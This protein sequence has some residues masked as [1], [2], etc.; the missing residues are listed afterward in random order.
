MHAAAVA[1]VAIVSLLALLALLALLSL[2][3]CRR[4]AS[5]TTISAD[6]P[7]ASASSRADAAPP[8]P[9]KPIDACVPAF[10]RDAPFDGAWL[11]AG[12][13][14]FCAKVAE[15]VP[16]AN[17]RACF[18]VELATGTYHARPNDLAAPPRPPST[19][20]AAYEAASLGGAFTFDLKGGQRTPHGATA[21][22]RDAKTSKKRTAA[23][24]Y[25][26]HLFFDGWVGDAV[27]LSTSVDE[28]P[29]CVRALYQPLKTWP[30]VLYAPGTIQ[31]GSCYGADD[32]V[33]DTPTRKKAIIDG[34]DGTLLLVEPT[35]L[36]VD[37]VESRRQAQG[38]GEFVA[39]TPSTTEVVI[40]FGPS[41]VGDFV[42]YD[43][44]KESLAGAGSPRVCEEGDAGVAPR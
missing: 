5:R 34:D 13:L 3:A 35:K 17:E 10:L 2:V 33:F 44:A 21:T 11:E 6:P 14:V 28:G 23:I 25:D 36:T 42:R 29:G 8:G 30:I 37:R 26:E 31:L 41:I 4:S 18:A 32:L 22:L 39:F 16:H 1:Q 12:G 24:A 40:L 7:P 43:L 20:R 27:A 9:P 38:P 15:G 19:R